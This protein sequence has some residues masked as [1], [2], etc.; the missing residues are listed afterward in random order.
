MYDIR[1]S[2]APVTEQTLDRCA[3]V[4][5]ESYGGDPGRAENFSFGMSA[6]GKEYYFAI[7]AGD[8]A[9][10]WSEVTCLDTPTKAY[11]YD[12]DGD[13]MCDTWE[14]ENYLDL[15]TDDSQ[16]DGDADG[17]TNREEFGYDTNPR[18]SDTDG[19]GYPDS[20]EV[21]L[22]TDPLDPDSHPRPPGD[23]DCDSAVTLAD[24]LIALR[25][26]ASKDAP[27]EFCL[28]DADGDG[29]IGLADAVFILQKIVVPE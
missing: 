22:G 14:W 28:S 23:L 7:R 29:R 20:E 26:A 12:D 5:S 10:N 13:G 6:R 4:I 25:L 16:N 24:A 8:V 27:P 17:L 2:R 21:S 3:S 11:M 18:A 19:D 9:G 15:T 1:H